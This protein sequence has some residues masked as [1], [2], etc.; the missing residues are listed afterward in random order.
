MAQMPG[1]PNHMSGAQQSA[2]NQPPTPTILNKQIPWVWIGAAVGLPLV[3]L[4][5]GV[6]GSWNNPP[7]APDSS[8]WSSWIFPLGVICGLAGFGLLFWKG[9]SAEAKKAGQQLLKAAALIILGG[10]LIEWLGPDNV[11]TAGKNLGGAI[12]GKEAFETQHAAAGTYEVTAQQ[13]V[14]E[15]NGLTFTIRDDVWSVF[16]WRDGYCVRQFGGV[17]LLEEG[18]DPKN[19]YKFLSPSGVQNVEVKLVGAG[20]SWHGD[21][22]P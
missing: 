4:V 6:I 8:S 9:G 16:T 17:G 3:A 20:E 2:K 22:C 21:V 18:N 14:G 13:F 10:L 5:I 19:T 15:A 1:N 11:D 12:A 7:E